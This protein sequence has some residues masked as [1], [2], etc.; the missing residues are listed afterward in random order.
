MATDFERY[1]QYVRENIKTQDA[2]ASG[3]LATSLFSAEAQDA[4]LSGPPAGGAALRGVQV[5]VRDARVGESVP[6]VVAD[7]RTAHHLHG[8]GQVPHH[9]P[10][11]GQLLIVLLAKD[12]EAGLGDAEEPGH[13][14]GDPLEVARTVRAAQA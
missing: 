10:D 2:K 5:L 3:F 7:E 11:D 14:R 13:H 12:R 1:L 8:H 9:A 4:A 6:V